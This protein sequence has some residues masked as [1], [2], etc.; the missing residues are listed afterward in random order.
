MAEKQIASLIVN[1]EANVEQLR[2]EMYNAQSEMKKARSVLK[3]QTDLINKNL[4]SI[5]KQAQS[6]FS[7][8][9]IGIA[10]IGM[11]KII[12]EAYEYNVQLERTKNSFA[13]FGVLQAD[14]L[15]YAGLNLSASEKYNYALKNTQKIMQEINKITGKTSHSSNELAQIYRAMYLP[16][17]NIGATNKD[18]AY[19]T[20]RLSVLA[21]SAGIELQAI[22]NSVDNI[23]DG[24]VK[25]NSEFGKLLKAVGLSNNA[26]KETDD[27]VG[28]IG[29]RLK[30]LKVP[31]SL[32]RSV[33]TFKTN[34][35]ELVGEIGKGVFG[36]GG[37]ELE[38]YNKQ[39]KKLVDSHKEANRQKE[40]KVLDISAITTIEDA[41]IKLAL[42]NKELEKAE[43]RLERI[44][45]NFLD[46]AEREINAEPVIKQIEKIKEQ[47]AREQE[48]TTKIIPKAIKNDE[49]A[50]Q[51]AAINQARADAEED[52]NNKIAEFSKN[53]R[54]VRIKNLNEILDAKRKA[55]ADEILIEKYKSLQMQQ[56]DKDLTAKIKK[57]TEER[58]KAAND[59]RQ[60]LINYESS[61]HKNSLNNEF[62]KQL[63][64][65][66]E[67]YAKELDKF[68]GMKNEQERL[69]IAYNQR[70]EKIEEERIKATANKQRDA[71]LE[72][73][74]SMGDEVKAAEI[75]LKKYSETVKQYEL[76]KNKQD[77]LINKAKYDIENKQ[78]QDKFRLNEQYYKA[79]GD[80]QSAELMRLERLRL[81]Y[82]RQGYSLEEINE[83]INGK[84][85][86]KHRQNQLL[87]TLGVDSAAF[88]L[89]DRFEEVEK[90]RK[91]EVQ[92]LEAYY[93][94]T[95]ELK[96]KSVEKEKAMDTIRFNSAVAT[97]GA[98]FSA[99]SSLA[100]QFYD[101][102]DGESK[103]A[104]RAY[105]TVAI[106][107][108]VVNTYLAAQKAYASAG[109]PYLGAALSAIAIAQ[110]MMNVA[111]IKKQKF[112]TGGLVRGQG[113]VDA[114]LL[115]GEGVLNR[116]AMNTIGVDKLN[117]LNSGKNTTT[118]TQITIIN[119]SSREEAYEIMASR[120]GRSIINEIANG[121]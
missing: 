25:P 118:E 114:T 111:E 83:M 62:D 107:E 88:G 81:E 115:S 26:L 95:E 65:E 63:Y 110:G 70:I 64:T 31:E 11:K 2:K 17:R 34:L 109:N 41:N 43:K 82:E 9:K 14:N 21:S 79:I 23:A 99:M 101:L 37:I 44:N 72:Y 67:T 5:G 112:H 46:I 66:T 86:G 51:T 106:G 6:A 15:K 3:K 39:L 29:E 89:Q 53:D 69:T 91:Q 104:A 38:F 54:D 60:S 42:T 87:S 116:K 27:V 33:A 58:I 77:D 94:A 121:G 55:G 93:S 61:T 35:Q 97:A 117:E 16:M 52:L 59:A 7:L 36:K 1:I 13:I 113:E 49:L 84:E 78:L 68:R 4:Q 56:I 103:K 74:K 19:M 24:T 90:Y 28:L 50:E 76:D 98:G 47:I 85:V 48:W 105:Q 18:I 100:K 80:W 32:E 12:T 30:D 10:G 8:V 71:L 73:Y 92:R 75:E 20:E 102:N 108:A 22:V 120:R 96:A 119:V 40:I 45:G 57:E